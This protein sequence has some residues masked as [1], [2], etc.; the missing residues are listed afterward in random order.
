MS[1]E[2]LWD[3][4]PTSRHL[5]VLYHQTSFQVFFKLRFLKIGCRTGANFSSARRERTKNLNPP[6]AEL[7]VRSIRFS[8]PLLKVSYLIEQGSPNCGSHATCGSS[9]LCMRP[10]ELYEKLYTCSLFLISTAKSSDEVAGRTFALAPLILRISE[11][12]VIFLV[13]SGK[14]TNFITVVTP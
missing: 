9:N 10:F 8:V 5:Q 1:D 2:K 13:P 4:S 7:C 11:K 12:K 6:R 3:E 14:R